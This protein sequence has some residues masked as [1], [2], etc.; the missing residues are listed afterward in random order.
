VDG[1]PGCVFRDTPRRLTKKKELLGY[2]ASQSAPLLVHYFGFKTPYREVSVSEAILGPNR[3]W[4]FSAFGKC[5]DLSILAVGF[6]LLTITLL[7]THEV[8]RALTF[9]LAPTVSPAKYL[10]LLAVLLAGLYFVR[11]V[12]GTAS[13]ETSLVV[14]SAALGLIFGAL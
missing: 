2:F 8:A 5:C 6:A 10:V 1:P 11:R 13:L 12:R 9:A 14:W 3:L 4:Q 7:T